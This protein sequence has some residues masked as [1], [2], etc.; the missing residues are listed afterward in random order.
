MPQKNNKHRLGK[1]KTLSNGKDAILLLFLFKRNSSIV[2]NFLPGS[3]FLIICVIAV[4]NMFPKAKRFQD[5]VSQAPPVGSYEIKTQRHGTAPG[6][7]KGKRFAELKD[8]GP[9]N[10]S[11]LDASTCSN[12]SQN[13][14]KCSGS[15]FAT[16]LPFRKSRKMSS[17]TP[18]P[19]GD[20]SA[21]ENEISRLLSER[22]ELENRLC[23]A[24]QQVQDLENKFQSLLQEKTCHESTIADL[25][26]EVQVLT[27]DKDQILVK[28]QAYLAAS[29]KLETLE[30]EL[31]TVRSQLLCKEG[32]ISTLK[33]QVSCAAENSRADLE[34]EQ[35]KNKAL[36]E[37][38]SSLDR[39]VSEVTSN[40]DEVEEANQKLHELIAQLR[41]ENIKLREKLEETE[42]KLEEIR[43]KM[44]NTLNESQNKI[45]ALEEMLGKEM[46]RSKE[47]GY[48]LECSL[49]QSEENFSEAQSRIIQ[50][51]EACNSFESKNQDLENKL[52]EMIEKEQSAEERARCLSVE[53]LSLES[54]LEECETDYE[55]RL[56]IANDQVE[57]LQ[58]ELKRCEETLTQNLRSLT[59]KYQ[60]LEDSYSFFQSEAEK[61]KQLILAELEV[62]KDCLQKSR[63]ES[64]QQQNTC[65]LLKQQ[66]EKLEEECDQLNQQL[67]SSKAEKDFMKDQLS[68]CQQ[69]L[70]TAQAEVKAIR[71]KMAK[72]L[73]ET[74]FTKD[75][76]RSSLE[77]AH[78]T[79]NELHQKEEDITKEL[80]HT[81][82]VREQRNEELEELKEQL[83]RVISQT[84]ENE[85]KLKEEVGRYHSEATALEE[86]LK[87]TEENFTRQ[88]KLYEDKAT[89]SK[90]E[91]GRRLVETQKKLSQTEINFDKFRSEQEMLMNEKNKEMERKIFAAEEE[92]N[93][94]KA[95]LSSQA[96]NDD[97]LNEY[98]AQ[99]KMWQTKYEELWKK[100]E[101][102]KDQ[103]D[104]Y[105][106]ERNALL[107]QNSQAK[108]EV[109]KLG[110][111][112]AKLLGH[113]NKK[114]KIHHVV[115]LKEE[116][117]S[118][119]NELAKLRDQC[120]KQKRTIKKLEERVDQ[121]SG[122]KRFNPEEAFSYAKKENLPLS[123]QEMEWS[124]RNLSEERSCQVSQNKS[125]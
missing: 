86:K 17:S 87:E 118:L 124:C 43:T 16:P 71:E 51:Q 7:G 6:F 82:S 79:I 13:G 69:E 104:E 119:K 28:L 58:E 37:R 10:S 93:R 53:K 25:Q 85:R 48:K 88:I 30:E 18:N 95:E 116:N 47:F 113:Q 59:G 57:S 78:K 5:T 29:S 21:L 24:Q 1:L 98:K 102:F 91:F 15:E 83:D 22:T 62:T 52:L 110:Q 114:Q 123:V 70:A 45:H 103:L 68:Q 19:K 64:D 50:L 90:E 35:E 65:M 94:L 54:R 101:P 115:K 14:T 111:Q 117:I 81:L 36:T 20:Q 72:Q 44:E 2:S 33:M 92:F 107:S 26:K 96:S 39:T 89:K 55:Q 34:L 8:T 75:S 76:L 125:E 122:K 105:E 49:K 41:S 97:Q 31:Q 60:D 40:R 109:A 108:D 66:S 63:Q 100:I 61:E 27:E 42:D 67:G 73:E 80:Q 38:I 112:Y 121:M 32:V 9:A 56:S 3:D 77:E 106:A 46:M 11:L 23:M 74:E 12:S 4:N 99:I 120:E 84:K